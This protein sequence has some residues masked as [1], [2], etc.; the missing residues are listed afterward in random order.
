MCSIAFS[1]DLPTMPPLGRNFTA[2][3][4]LGP[5]LSKIQKV[6]FRNKA[7]TTGTKKKHPTLTNTICMTSPINM[8][9]RGGFEP[10]MF[11]TWVLGLQPSAF[12]RFATC[13]WWSRWWDSNPHFADFE[14]ADSANWS[15]SGCFDQSSFR[16]SSSLQYASNQKWRVPMAQAQL[17]PRRQLAVEL[18]GSGWPLISSP[19][20]LRVSLNFIRHREQ[21]GCCLVE[22]DFDQLHFSSTQLAQPSCYQ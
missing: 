2:A 3:Q 15:T 14:S 20:C 22:D 10:P 19:C 16:E 6:Y 12:N 7:S 1:F 17:S 18:V 8:V 4:P 11:T 9:G 13:P 5:S 21:F